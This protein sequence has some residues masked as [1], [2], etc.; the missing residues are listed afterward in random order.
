MVQAHALEATA[1]PTSR[2]PGILAPLLLAEAD[3]AEP[4]QPLALIGLQFSKCFDG[5]GSFVGVVA[6]YD[7]SCG[8]RLEYE[9]GDEEDLTLEE[10]LKL[11]LSDPHALVGRKLSKHFPGHGRFDGVVA[12]YSEQMLKGVPVGFHVR[13]TDGDTEHI[14]AAELLR[15]LQ[16]EKVGKRRAPPKASSSHSAPDAGGGSGDGAA[17]TLP[18]LP[19]TD[20]QAL[21]GRKLSKEFPGH[22]WFSG[23]VVSYAQQTGFLVE[24]EDGDTEDLSVVK[25][26]QL[27]RQSGNHGKPSKRS[28]AAPSGDGV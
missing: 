2:G 3:D 25:L 27:L 11:P 12:S 9:D 20:P 8:Y 1:I 28:R 6:A 15:L 17:E 18:Q 24:Y 16:P 21:V 23:T 13:Y 26:L 5:Q 4:P 19:L 14:F 10:L 22:G 7:A